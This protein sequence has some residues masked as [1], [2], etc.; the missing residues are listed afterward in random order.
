MTSPIVK[1]GVVAVALAGAA[2]A[3][4]QGPGRAP[5]A[6]PPGIASIGST[7]D[8]LVAS[9]MTGKAEPEGAS[10]RDGAVIAVAT[11]LPP[12]TVFSV[13]QG[14]RSKSDTGGKSP[15]EWMLIALGLFLVITISQRRARSLS[16]L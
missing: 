14:A 9:A 13:G 15:K 7:S 2:L 10:Q 5:T 1:Y 16:D 6:T 8:Y 11:S 4:A 12:S 3:Y